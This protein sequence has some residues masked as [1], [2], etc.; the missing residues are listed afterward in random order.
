MGYLLKQKVQNIGSELFEI[1]TQIKNINLV[2]RRRKQL[3]KAATKIFVQKGYHKASI[4]EIALAS[5]LSMG[6]LYAYIAKKED[7]LYLVH[8]DM[9]HNIY[10]E[11]F[12]QVEE[13]T[14]IQPEDLVEMVRNILERSLKFGDEIILIYRETGS[15]SK[16]LMKQI[17][18]LEKKYTGMLRDVLDRTK[19]KATYS[20]GETNFIA[21]LIV[22]L[23]A[24]LALRRWNLKAYDSKKSIELML[25]YIKLMLQFPP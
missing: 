15:L 7:I 9:I 19:Q 23:A 22:Y 8:E 14:E 25:K 17:L 20:I 21:N 1:P 16:D 2:Q 11:L 10:K 24:F 6:N 12:D 5:K 18:S 3:V 4:R 13:G